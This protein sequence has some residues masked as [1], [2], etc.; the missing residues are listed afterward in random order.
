MFNISVIIPFYNMEKTLNRCI[1]SVISQTLP[2]V[3][4]I[5]IDN[6]SV[7]GSRAVI[8]NYMTR[9]NNIALYECKIKGAGPTRNVGLYNATGKYIAFMDADDCYTSNDALELLYSKAEEMNVLAAG[10]TVGYM[11][12]KGNTAVNSVRRYKNV[13]YKDEMISMED[14]QYCYAFQRFI[15]RREL[16]LGNHIEFPEYLRNEDPIFLVRVLGAAG[17]FYAVSRQVYTSIGIKKTIEFQN[18]KL[19]NDIVKGFI[20]ML[21]YAGDRDYCELQKLVV[22]ELESMKFVFA[23]HVL[24][25]NRE[26]SQL[27]DKVYHL[28]LPEIKDGLSEGQKWVMIPNVSLLSYINAY[29]QKWQKFVEKLKAYHSAVIYGA[30]KIG[31]NV[32]AYLKSREINVAGFAVS[33][34]QTIKSVQGKEIHEL[35]YYDDMK[36]K[37]IVIIAKA[38]DESYEM[39]RNA[40][41]MGFINTVI[42]SESIKDVQSYRLI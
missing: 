35:S 26:I 39:Q 32:Y 18:Q 24:K 2:K 3:E 42:V 16:I 40:M 4:I 7:D 31:E 34:M 33:Q 28:L 27:L 29:E 17:K 1:D 21:S 23:L 36:E 20:D 41:D 25:G 6:N 9:Y 22:N 8:Q 38:G 5:C 30:G 11:T 19:L 14:F 13:F 10:G 15:F 37:A 12:E